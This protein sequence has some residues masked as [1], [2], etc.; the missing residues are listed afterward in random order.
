MLGVE[1]DRLAG[2]YGQASVLVDGRVVARTD[3]TGWLP[4]SGIVIE[5]VR[6]ALTT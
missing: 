2:P 6:A 1:V 5:R 4:R 3:G